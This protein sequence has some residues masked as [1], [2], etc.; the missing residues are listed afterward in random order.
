MPLFYA[1]FNTFHDVFDGPTSPLGPN[2]S[3]SN[4]PLPALA[5]PAA[6]NVVMASFVAAMALLGVG[7]SVV[8]AGSITA[9]RIAAGALA[10]GGWGRMARAG[11]LL[12]LVTLS[13]VAEVAVVA[14]VF[15][16]ATPVR[17]VLLHVAPH[18][19]PLRLLQDPFAQVVLLS[20]LGAM[21][22][23]LALA[24]TSDVFD[25][26]LVVRIARRPAAVAALAMTGAL[27]PTL[28]W[29]IAIGSG[30]LLGTLPL[31][32]VDWW[33][34]LLA[35]GGMAVAS[36]VALGSVWSAFSL[37]WRSVQARLVGPEA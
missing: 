11:G 19:G 29:A 9:G 20:A 1:A 31:G 24:P 13:G 23:G 16:N 32:A 34:M 17:E 25:M 30:Q 26:R 2:G 21:L 33:E 36:V 14:T 22:L 35:L 4:T 5:G 18:D 6:E 15:P 7:V 28:I 37:N 8:A 10:A 3:L 12:G 27:V